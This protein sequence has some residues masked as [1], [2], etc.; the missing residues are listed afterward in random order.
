MIGIVTNTSLMILTNSLFDFI[1][2]TSADNKHVALLGAFVVWE[3]I[4]VTIKY[5]LQ[6]T[7]PD[8]SAQLI[9]KL[10]EEEHKKNEK[11]KEE[12]MD[13]N[14]KNN[15]RKSSIGTISVR[16]S[17]VHNDLYKSEDDTA[18]KGIIK[19]EEST[20]LSPFRSNKVSDKHQH[21]KQQTSLK[22]RHQHKKHDEHTNIKKPPPITPKFS[23]R[24][25]P[26]VKA[27][28]TKNS[29]FSQFLPKDDDFS[30]L[31]PKTGIDYDEESQNL[32]EML[33]LGSNIHGNCD[34]DEYRTPLKPSMQRSIK[35]RHQQEE[36]DAAQ[37]RIRNRLSVTHRN[38]RKKMY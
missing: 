1:R 26:A 15:R 35:T 36:L 12:V 16:S 31:V 32:S 17:G 19:K 5:V 33:S 14:L 2:E 37:Q 20:E 29:P 18:F 23:K 38:E 6:F 30:P 3:R 28:S 4:M 7:M 21:K 8:K 11:L 10:K 9:R 13:R 25:G 24:S 22:K 27:R 34:K